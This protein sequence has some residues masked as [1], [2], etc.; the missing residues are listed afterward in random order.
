VQPPENDVERDYE[1]LATKTREIFA[2]VSSGLV[3]TMR[4]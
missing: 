2:R 4:P 3:R 1:L